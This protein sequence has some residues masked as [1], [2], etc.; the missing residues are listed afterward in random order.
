MGVFKERKLIVVLG[1][2]VLIYGFFGYSGRLY[3]AELLFNNLLEV[4]YLREESNTFDLDEW[5][6]S[7]EGVIE[8]TESLQTS[9]RR[10]IW[11]GI[12]LTGGSI[13]SLI[14]KDE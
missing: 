2:V 14:I 1:I 3:R 8:L 13:F 6:D 5:N 9:R 7:M 11:I 4:R 10:T 12:F